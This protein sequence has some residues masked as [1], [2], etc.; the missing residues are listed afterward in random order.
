MRKFIFPT[1]EKK[2]I[3]E[4]ESDYANTV[5]ELM[6]EKSRNDEHDTEIADIWYQM[7]TGGNS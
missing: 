3:E 4:L 1:E 5:Y 6:L 7:M 2:Q